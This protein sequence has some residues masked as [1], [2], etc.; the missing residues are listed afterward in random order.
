MRKLL[1]CRPFSPESSLAQ[2]VAA[3]APLLLRYPTL[4]QTQIVFNYAGDL[5]IVSREGGEARQLTS[6][7]GTETSPQFSPDG[8]SIA[9]TG[10]YDG[11]RD[12]YVI[13]S[14]GR[15][16]EAPDIPSCAGDRASA[17][18]RMAHESCSHPTATAS[19][20]TRTSS[21]R[22]PQP[23]V[24]R[25]SCRCPSSRRPRSRRTANISP[26]CRIRSG[27]RPGSA[28]GAAR[29]RPSGSRISRIRAS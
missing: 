10:E 1:P 12:V 24:S 7:V 28:I 4:S 20:T 25:R 26:T 9:F 27:S 18:R 14:S 13:P 19:A 6:G 2:P 11:N 21:I 3:D 23:G 5:W 22:C 15:R 16:A 8:A 29:P 17:G